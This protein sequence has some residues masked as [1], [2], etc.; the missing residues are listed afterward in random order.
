ME[1]SE[2]FEALEQNPSDL[3]AL[4]A[5][6]GACIAETD[7]ENLERAYA[8]VLSKLED[9]KDVEQILRRIEMKIRQ[10]PDEDLQTWMQFYVGFQYWTRLDNADKAEM[11][12]RKIGVEDGPYLPVLA[13][14]YKKFYADKE[15]WRRLEDLLMKTADGEDETRAAVEVKRELARLAEE[16]DKK[17]KAV[18]FWAGLRQLDATDEEA[19][20]RLK[21]LYIEVQKWHSLIELL[22]EKLARLGDGDVA[23]KISIQLE[24]VEIFREHIRSETKVNSAYQAILEL[25]PNNAMALDALVAQYTEMKRWPD[26]VRV[27]QQKVEYTEDQGELI[28]LHREIAS[29]MQ[30][31]FSN[32]SEAIKSYTAIL[33]LDPT[34]REAIA[35]LKD[36][37]DKRRDWEHYIEISLAEV[38]LIEDEDAK[39][40]ATIGLAELA[41]ERIRKPSVAIDLWARVLARDSEN[42]S[43]LDSLEQLYEREKDFPALVDV[44]EKKLSITESAKDRLD[45]LQKLA[46]IYGSR[47]EDDD[48]TVLTW[49]RVLEL[50]PEDRKAQADLKKRFLRAGDWAELEWFFRNFGTVEELVRTIESQVGSIEEDQEKIALLFKAARIWREELDSTRRA[51]KDLENVLAIAPEHLA[52]AEMLIPIY[53]ELEQWDSLPP[54]MEIKLQHTTERAEREGLF[55]SLAE[56]HETHLGDPEQA[57][58]N[59]VEAYKENWQDDVIHAEMERLAGVSGNWASYVLVLEETLEHVD[60]AAYR[61]RYRTRIAQVQETEL[62]DDE[63]ALASYLAVLE[64]DAE[65]RT[66]LDAIE[67]LYRKMSRWSD[68]I[69]VLQRKLALEESADARKEIMFQLGGAWRDFMSNNEEAVKVYREMLEQFP[70]E[71]RV[72][73]ELTNIFLEEEAY[74]ALRDVLDR[75]LELLRRQDAADGEIAT[76]LC[77]LGMLTYGTGVGDLA[78][79]DDLDPVIDRYE[80]ALQVDRDSVRAVALLEELLASE[81]ARPRIAT[82]LEPVYARREEWSKLADIHEIQLQK[83]A[84]DE[85]DVEKR[86]SLLEKLGELYRDRIADAALAFRSFARIFRLDPVDEDVRPH[87]E[88]LAGQLDRWG[89]LVGLYR[90]E[91]ERIDVPEIRLDVLLTIARLYHNEI[92]DL[93]SAQAF[94]NQVL[95]IDPAHAQ[96]LDALE[97]IYLLLERYEDLLQVY[98]RKIELATDDATRLRYLFDASRLWRDRLGNADEAIAAAMRIL[99]VD[100]A[101]KD[102]LQLLDELY[103]T[104]ERWDDL[105]DTLKRLIDLA[106]ETEQVV[107]LKTRLASVQ[108]NRQEDVDA[109]IKTYASILTLDAANEDAFDALERLFADL[110]WSRFIAPILEPHYERRGDWENL[111]AVYMVEESSAG[112]DLDERVALRFKISRLYEERGVDPASAFIHYSEAY[113][114]VP[115]REDTLAALLRLADTLANY[116]ELVLL[117]EERVDDVTDVHRKREIHRVAARISRDSVGDVER[118]KKHFRAVLDI[119]PDDLAAL[120]ALIDLHRGQDEW[121]DLVEVLLQK[122]PLVQDVEDRKV[123]YY[124]AGEISDLRLDD[125][126]KAIEIYETLR[127]LDPADPTALDPLQSLYER[128]GNWQ[129]LV[130]VYSEKIDRSDD[131]D[132][133]KRFATEKARVQEEKQEAL[134][135]A[136]GT[137]R[138]VLEWDPAD[139]PALQMLDHLYSRKEDWYSLL[140]VLRKQMELVDED[141]R[142]ALQFRAGQIQETQ[143]EDIVQAIDAYRTVLDVQIDHTGALQALEAIVRERDDRVLA[144]DV[145]RPVLERSDA[146]PTLIELYEVI[147]AAEPDDFRKID[148]YTTMGEIAET[149]LGEAQRAF[150]FHGKAF[151]LDVERPGTVAQLERLAAE[152]GLWERIVELYVAGAEDAMSPEVQLTLRLKV[153]A[154]LKDRIGDDDRAVKHYDVLHEDYPDNLEV[155]QALDQ[156]YEFREDWETLADILRREIEIHEHVE[157]KIALQFRLGAI[158]ESK[159]SDKRAA[160]ECYSD[161]LLLDPQ[162]A[163][164]VAHLERLFQDA[165]LR[166]DIADQLENIYVERQDWFAL[167]RMLELKLE[168]LTDEMDR[169]ELL[170][171]LAALN[172]ETLDRKAETVSWLGKA[173]VL[174]PE[175]EGML[176]QLFDL[177]EETEQWGELTDVLLEAVERVGIDDRKIELW[178]RAAKVLEERLHDRDRAESIYHNVLALDEENL[179]ALKSL[180]RIYSEIERW[181]DLEG[182]LKREIDVQ[183]YDDDKVEL[184]TRLA[185]LYRDRLDRWD[186]AVTAYRKVIDI[187]D[188]HRPSLLALAEIYETRQ[189][190]PP[191]FGVSQSLADV[192]EN[193]D[194]RVGYLSRMA[195]IAEEQLGDQKDAIRLWE[196]VLTVRPGS[197]EAV[198]ELQRLMQA[199]GDWQGYVETCERELRM[200]VDDRDRRIRLHKEVGRAWRDRLKDTFQA[201]EAWQKALEEEPEDREALEALRDLYRENEAYEPLVDVLERMIGVGG[202]EG[203]TLIGLWRE[204]AQIKTTMLPDPREA[205]HAWQNVLENEPGDSEAIEALER[206]YESEGMWDRCVEI[207]QRRV[208]LLESLEDKVDALMR[209]ARIQQENL[210]DA[211]AAAGTYEQILS[212]EPT[213][214][215]ASMALEKIYEGQGDHEALADLLKRR[216]A[217]M[218]D[219]ADKVYTLQNLAKLFEEK[220][221]STDGAFEML[222]EALQVEPTDPQTLFEIE[223]VAT[224]SEMWGE[225][226]AI[227]GEVVPQ[228][229]EPHQVIEYLTKWAK[230]LR[231]KLARPGEAIDRFRKVL[232]QDAE[233]EE[234]L[235]ALVALY[236]SEERWAD[237]I[238]ALANLVEVSYDALEQV[239]FQRRIGEI[240]EARLEDADAAIAAYTKVLEFEETDAEALQA[241]ERLD[242]DGERW[243][244]LIAILRSQAQAAPERDTEIRLRVGEL[245]EVKLDNVQEAVGTYEDILNFDPTNG[246]ALSRLEALYFDR[247]DWQKLT[248]V[249]ERLLDVAQTTEER[250]QFCKNLAQLYEQAFSDPQQAADSYKRILELQPSNS[251]ALQALER[252]YAGEEAWED[253]IEVHMRWFELTD[254]PATR[255]DRL[256]A[257]ARVYAEQ[258][259]D[260]DNAIRAYERVLEI[261]AANMAALDALDGLYRRT[262]QWE[263]VVDVLRRKGEATD[264][265][266]LVSQIEAQRGD[267]LHEQ[268]RDIPGAVAAYESAFQLATGAASV[269]LGRKLVTA[270]E[271]AGRWEDAI[272]VLR[273]INARSEDPHDKADAWCDMA[274]LYHRHL[275][276]RD[277]AVD[278]YERTLEID[279]EHDRALMALATLY[280]EE[281]AW[282]RALPRL[283]MQLVRIDEDAEPER[284][285]ELYRQIAVAAENVLD[286]P[287]ALDFYERAYHLDSQDIRTL[288]GLAR[289]YY[290]AS[291][292]EQSQ[293]F[294]RES[295]AA[296]EDSMT[297]DELVE[298]YRALGDIAFK[299][300]DAASAYEYLEKVLLYQPNNTAAIEDL[301]KLAEGAEDW[302]AAIRYKHELKSATKDELERLNILIDIGDTYREQLGDENGAV[303]SYREALSIRPDSRAA[304][305]KLLEIFIQSKRYDDAISVLEKLVEGSDDP[306]QKSSYCFT[307]SVIYRDQ[308][309]DDERAVEYLDKTLDLNPKRKEA[310][311]YIDEIMTRR[312]DWKAQ[313][314]Y[315]RKMIQR[316]RGTGETELEFQLYRNLGE[317]YRSRMKNF[318]YAQSA[319]ALAAQIRP[320]DVQVHEILAELY[321]FQGD[322]DKAVAEHLALL[323]YQPDRIASYRAIKQLSLDTRKLDRAW[324]AA[325]V[326]GLLNQATDEEQKF[327]RQ[328]RAPSVKEARG[329]LDANIWRTHVFADPTDFL[330]GQV[331]QAV[332]LGIGGMLEAKTLKDLGLKKRDELQPKKELMF[333]NTLRNVSRVLGIASPHVYLSERAMGVRIEGTM[334]PVLLVGP[335]MLQGKTE[336]EMAFLLGKL[337]NYFHPMH[338]LAGVFPLPMLQTLLVCAWRYCYPD[339]P[340]GVETQQ[341][342]D[343][344]REMNKAISQQLKYSFVRAMDQFRKVYG[345]VTDYDLTGW[346]QRV[347]LTANHAGLLCCGD[348]EMAGHLITAEQAAFSNLTVREKVK[349][350]VLYAVDA[351]F[352]EIRERLGMKIS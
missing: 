167:H 352:A 31:K 123:I 137:W 327:Y 79:G 51:V 345:S 292:Y 48:N 296:A 84:A 336:T 80:E 233:H 222:Y 28:K 83:M 179:E 152:H 15:N 21:V 221:G 18:A 45:V 61:I 81:E 329:Q 299:L 25:Q 56:I 317:I 274:V 171:R 338:L 11:L 2:L 154:F 263:Q 54:V 62:R 147:V 175:D 14:F 305:I 196:E 312:R 227:Y 261:D 323:T 216:V 114:L 212:L 202:Y 99:D 20:E 98:E 24:M 174:D 17:D 118:A 97:E 344:V 125:P 131:L 94:Y 55:L 69:D 247:E 259:D 234:T 119:D 215:D 105:A 109:A 10:V 187:F 58:F 111:I 307:I 36:I 217:T 288:K 128:V 237:M 193:D 181:D 151:V 246:E 300:D 96:S 127:Q 322:Y 90:D 301:V 324:L 33:E 74:P 130:A 224:E 277:G 89:E 332:Y 60:D 3:Q 315:Y 242:A 264:D 311:A 95:G 334:P 241:L 231:D 143:L 168:V 150:E 320:D 172:L 348:I 87:L 251:E 314:R 256:S 38:D 199:T 82:L 5:I 189:E 283:E 86:I 73:E 91:V 192:A 343:I 43:A 63:S 330:V 240:Y 149:R 273:I 115:E 226:D 223:R 225:L 75:R 22:N 318:E 29:I 287:R 297:A 309:H 279:P 107:T 113:R 16:K 133:K 169:L 207:L 9:P 177:V 182:V 164:T 236:E 145:L 285:L 132:E 328:H 310:F 129:E 284:A 319:F 291:R 245:Y 170:K 44:L 68:L 124:E 23:A 346:M 42:R 101:D 53:R 230:L 163:D 191:L 159:L 134:D 140:D 194:E 136:V 239:Q 269:P 110:D 161:V 267:V 325:G 157:Q 306:I 185:E 7:Q 262:E 208:T 158:A 270:Y 347:E 116:E 178:H 219:P 203:E 121:E 254:D 66:A 8:T 351:R 326:L 37:Y 49:K 232:E 293:R 304:N 349:D 228:I 39:H 72:H 250:V 253:L 303:A 139:L 186:E 108:E 65:N 295:V 200:G 160:F 103:Q 112:D 144:F 166:I 4:D 281:G 117:I 294:Y 198:Q 238:E 214:Y 190:W 40:T 255:A 313:A 316:I 102:A 321:S 120:D 27:L 156:L 229:D 335:D 19:E 205:I 333:L 100:P 85:V 248:E 243:E 210:S 260:V 146:W 126:E 350:V 47:L 155:L 342:E 13:D 122:A 252:I 165:E 162:N 302:Q 220:L 289:L 138:R 148:L 195:R 176:S 106:E 290:K 6:Q 244:D 213:N 265:A 184:L 282:V 206:L 180:D 78:T 52:A 235:R 12:F 339:E 30:D 183:P 197:Y 77:D 34:D 71:A 268:I 278:A 70:D 57:F 92:E 258:L 209:A 59:Y 173:F 93:E 135:D 64:E 32:S 298:T 257:A 142:L 280:T 76:V 204:L 286:E 331:F 218:E 153:G 275:D 340:V 41:S 104:N 337:L 201:Q 26:L 188:N 341:V 88:A 308:L 272:Q 276:D 266:A 46:M 249:Y 50:D 35:T 271:A 1:I 67:G 211:M 141:E